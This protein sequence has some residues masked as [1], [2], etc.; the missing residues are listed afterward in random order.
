MAQETQLEP[1]E[2][3]R[4]IGNYQRRVALQ[5]LQDAE[6]TKFLLEMSEI[7]NI[8][9]MNY[10]GYF[11]D[12]ES[13]SYKKV[14]D[15]PILNEIGIQ[16]ARRQFNTFLNKNAALANLDEQGLSHFII[17]YGSRIRLILLTNLEEFGVKNVSTVDEVKNDIVEMAY[18]VLSRSL[19]LAGFSRER[20]LIHAGR[21]TVEHHSFTDAP[22][23]HKKIKLGW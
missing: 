11:F 4:S 6:I 15:S 7:A 18:L 8:K 21:K 2:K 17:G 10:K 20:D 3:D 13:R 14:V 9:L 22:P 19:G 16:F 23:E 5:Q 1:E 12:P